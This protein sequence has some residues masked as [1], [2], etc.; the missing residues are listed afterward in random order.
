MICT[1]QHPK[2]DI[3]C[4]PY[5]E[6]DLSMSPRQGQT[7]GAEDH[8]DDR[9]EKARLLVWYGGKEDGTGHG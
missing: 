2:D 8:G 4:G 7:D 1:H 9:E 3:E 5:G 6:P